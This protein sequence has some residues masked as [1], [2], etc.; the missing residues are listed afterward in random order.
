MRILQ[1][2]DQI[3]RHDHQRRKN[4]NGPCQ[5]G[6]KKRLANP[7]HGKTSTIFLGIWKLLQKVH[8]SLFQS[9]STSEQPDKKRQEI[10]MDHWMPRSVWHL[11]MMIHWRTSI[12]NAWPVKTVLSQIRCIKSSNRSC[13]YSIGFEWRPTPCSIHVKNIHG[14]WKEIW[15]INRELLGIIWALKEWRHYIQGSGHITI[16]F[17]DHKNLMYFRTA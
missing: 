6:R 17:S 3:S 10:W 7:Y 11:E 15:N 16:I 9:C 5:T 8:F 12:V 2:E 14:Y 13:T 1:D 4:L